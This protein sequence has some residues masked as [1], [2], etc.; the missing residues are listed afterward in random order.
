MRRRSF[1]SLAAFALVGCGNG[2]KSTNTLRVGLEL[3][4]PPFEMQGKDGKPDGTSI[5]LAEALAASLGKT[6]QIEVMTFAGLEMA[7]KTGK[8]DLILSSMTDTPERRKSLDFSDAYCRIGLA[9][10]AAKSSPVQ[11]GADLNAAGRKIIVRLKTTAEAFARAQ[12]PLATITP[13]DSESAALLEITSGRADVFIYDQ[14]SI[15]RLHASQPETTRAILVPLQQDNWAIALRQGEADLKG[16]VS[17]F[18]A[19]YRKSGG[20]DK[21][22]ATYLAKEKAA[23]EAAGVPFIFQ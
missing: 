11:A 12:Y 23:L 14:L 4:T 3:S 2:T 6:L 19:D 17:S 13:V 15:L 8:I 5:R 22:A 16:Q 10:L 9:L 7:L 1:V 20:F 21:L 18:L